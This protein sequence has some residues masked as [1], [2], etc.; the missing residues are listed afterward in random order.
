MFPTSLADVLA[1]LAN[2]AIGL[3][4]MNVGSCM[5]VQ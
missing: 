5:S 1:N 3:M 2:F 4:L